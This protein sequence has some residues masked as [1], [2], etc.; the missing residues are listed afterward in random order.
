MTRRILIA[1]VSMLRVHAATERLRFV[2][3]AQLVVN[4]FLRRVL[5]RAPRYA[6]F[7]VS[8]VFSNQLFHS[9][10]YEYKLEFPHCVFH[11]QHVNFFNI[12]IFKKILYGELQD[13][14]IYIYKCLYRYI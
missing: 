2:T 5:Y 3:V 10:N 11:A 13:M 14:Y 12:N 6:F 8:Q 4:H 1:T 9:P 7:F